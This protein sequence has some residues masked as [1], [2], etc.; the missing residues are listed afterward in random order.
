ME[1]VHPIHRPLHESRI[2]NQDKTDEHVATMS[3][4]E[5]VIRHE[6][7]AGSKVEGRSKARGP[8]NSGRIP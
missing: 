2:V 8:Q 7:R 5:H 1:E 6:P 4:H 3:R